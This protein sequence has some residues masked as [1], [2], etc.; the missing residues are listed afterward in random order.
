MVS[1]IR[2]D[3]FTVDCDIIAH[4]VNCRGVMGAGLAKQIR[5]KYPIVYERYKNYCP[6]PA[7][8]GKVQV[9]NT[10]TV[11]VANLFAQEGFGRDKRYTDYDALNNCLSKLRDY[12]VEHDLHTLA[13]P[14]GLGCGLAGGDWNK[15]YNIIK[16]VFD[17]EALVV[18]VCRLSK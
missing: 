17:N 12:M 15:V 3:I 8:L 2:R 5:N 13:L 7:L 4:Q 18:Y 16:D 6:D 1:I 14:Y 11:Y 10:G 9:I